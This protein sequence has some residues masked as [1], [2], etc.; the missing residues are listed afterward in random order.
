M[1]E[2]R[3]IVLPALAAA[4]A[5][6]AFVRCAEAALGPAIDPATVVWTTPNAFFRRG[7]LVGY[8]L[9]LLLG[10]AALIEA[11]RPG[12]SLVI[13]CWL[14]PFSFVAIVVQTALWP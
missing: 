8:L 11:R 13:T 5:L 9:A 3:V 6:Y 14:L 1:G 12:L 2:R 10:T 7:L 4:P